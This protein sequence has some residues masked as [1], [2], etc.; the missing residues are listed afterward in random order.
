MVEEVIW[1]EQT[2]YATRILWMFDMHDC[3][4]RSTPMDNAIKLQAREAGEEAFD[5]ERYHQAIGCLLYL[6][7]GS[8]PDMVYAVT[9]LG[10][11]FKDPSNTNWIAVKQ[12]LRYLK[13]TL[14]MKLPLIRY[15]PCK[16]YLVGFADADHADDTVASK[17]TSGFLIYAHDILVLSKSKKQHLVAQ[18]TIKAELVVTKEAWKNLQWLGNMLS[19]LGHITTPREARLIY[20]HNESQGFQ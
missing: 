10:R 20:N 15:V 3:H 1:I 12:L 2:D 17:S 9:L 13:V 8:R 4:G 11:F 14:D 7:M 6:G 19:E 16:E 18:S 5:K